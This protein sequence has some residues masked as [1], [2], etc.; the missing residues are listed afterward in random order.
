MTFIAKYAVKGEKYKRAAT[1]GKAEMGKRYYVKFSY[2]NPKHNWLLQD[3]P[4]PDSLKNAPLDGW[5]TIP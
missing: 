3:R 2:L 1:K 4:V 5:K